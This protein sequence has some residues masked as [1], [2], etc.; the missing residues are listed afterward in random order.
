MDPT[1]EHGQQSQRNKD[2][3]KVALSRKLIFS[4]LSLI[5]GL[6]IVIAVAD[7]QSLQSVQQA[8]ATCVGSGG[9]LSSLCSGSSIPGALR[10]A[11][12]WNGLIIIVTLVLLVLSAILASSV[13]RD[14]RR[15]NR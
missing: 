13:Y 6:T 10:S 14:W 11:M 9:S 7:Y 3:K 15:G 4:Y 12:D 5:L 8:L 2:T 1:V